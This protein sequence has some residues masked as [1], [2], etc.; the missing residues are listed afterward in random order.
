MDA[1][2]GQSFTLPVGVVGMKYEFL[3]TVDLTSN[4][5]AVLCNTDTAGDFLVG[6]MSGAIESEATGEDW[7]ANGTTHLGI[8]SNKT[9]TGGLIGSMITVECVAANLWKISG[10]QSCTAT[11]ATPF[12][13]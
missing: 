2:A 1:A 13:T 6:Y 12:T 3:T 7:F 4:A 11:P 5:Y 8:S 9:T 10:V